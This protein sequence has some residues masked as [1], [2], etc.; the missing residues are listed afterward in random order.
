MKMIT[1]LGAA[2]IAALSPAPA[3]AQ[4]HSQHQGHGAHTPAPTPTP[5][6]PPSIPPMD[7]S[8]MGHRVTEYDTSF[9]GSNCTTKEVPWID[10]DDEII[11]SSE[12]RTCHYS[13]GSGSSR[14]PGAEG[15][16]SG[17]HIPAG[18]DWMVMAHGYVWGVYTDQS[19]PRGDDKL[20]VQSMIGVMAER[21]TDWGRVQFKSMFS[22]EP[23]MSNRG[24]PNLFASGETAGGLSLVDRQHP[25]DFFMELSARV[26]VNIGRKASLFIYGGPIGEPAI[27]PAAFMHRGS[28]RYNPEA[29]I[30]HHWFDSTHIT[31]GVATVGLASR[32]WQIEGSVFTGR[33]PDEERWGFDKMRFDSW[34]VRGTLT[35][36]PNWA[37][38]LSYGR[39][40]E[41]EPTHPGVDT[42]KLTA[43]V[44]YAN[45]KGLSAT[46]AFGLRDSIPGG[47]NDAWLGELNWDITDRHIVFGRI[48]NVKNSELFPDHSDPLHDQP[49][50]VTKFQAGYAYRLPITDSVGLALGG[51]VSTFA[52]PDVL[53]AAYGD[54][55]MG[56]TLFARLSL[57]H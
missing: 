56:Y 24:Y 6:P 50:R 40:K 55:P 26:D 37:M 57:G 54:N 48:E 46:A 2:S 39:F 7:H 36:S 52:K 18:D 53:D 25:H 43:S 5:T 23:I 33:E 32:L 10:E 27:G 8:K 14:L 21:D 13:E 9:A 19:G 30:T 49:F 38:Q 4:D 17:L 28:S 51:T 11:G 20:Y 42:A 16:H 3:S 34:S 31:Y 29:P 41:P 35:P 22:L 15:S 47:T 1:L 45:G 12:F 44:H